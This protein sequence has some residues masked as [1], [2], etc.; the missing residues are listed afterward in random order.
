[1]L[2]PILSVFQIS[3]H[4]LPVLS[5]LV[6]DLVQ[7]MAGDE[8]VGRKQLG[9]FSLIVSTSSY[10]TSLASY[11]VTSASGLPIICCC[12]VSMQSPAG[13]STSSYQITNPLNKFLLLYIFR[14]VPLFL[15]GP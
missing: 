9:Y 1:M 15:V 6:P 3:T 14:M 11:Q 4:G 8:R 13:F 5:Q 7:S 10:Q 2:F 12:Q